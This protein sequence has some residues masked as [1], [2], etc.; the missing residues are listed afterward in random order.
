LS[1]PDPLARAVFAVLVLASFAAFAVTQRLK[2]TPTVVQDIEMS[3]SFRPGATSSNGVE[4]ISFKLEHPDRVTV[5]V[6]DSQG[7][8]V[9]TLAR[10]LAMPAYKLF[11][12]YWNGHEAHG[13]HAPPGTYRV[14][15]A[16]ARQKRSILTPAAFE[17]LGGAPR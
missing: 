7:D 6:V 10:S 9:R 14:R 5:T 16:L 13:R 8:T 15:I 1:G 17:L 4:R 12:L 3:A 11:S 2:H